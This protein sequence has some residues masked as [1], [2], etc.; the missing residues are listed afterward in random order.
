M[1]NENETILT[2]KN[3][4][5][6]LADRMFDVCF[7][8]G[9]ADP[10]M[11]FIKDSLIRFW[12]NP[13]I[14]IAGTVD[15]HGIFKRCSPG[16]AYLATHAYCEIT[17]SFATIQP[18]GE[19]LGTVCNKQPVFIE[20]N[21]PVVGWNGN[22]H[23]DHHNPGDKGYGG[24]PEHYW[25]S[26]SV[27]QVYNLLMF[28]GAHP[29]KLERAFLGEKR[30]LVAAS[31]H[32]PSHAY[33]GRCPGIDREAPHLF[34]A[35]TS[36]AFNRMSVDE[37]LEAVD[38]A[39]CRLRNLAVIQT[40]HGG[41]SIAE[42][43]IDMLNQASLI[44][45]MAVQYQT[46]GNARDPRRKMGILGGSPELVAHWMEHARDPDGLGLVNVYGDPARG[47]AGGYVAS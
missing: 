47:Y 43:E 33:Q 15:E 27:G 22:Y 10:E 35:E 19:N 4:A 7:I 25:E 9:A 18:A 37:W 12:D 31:D 1:S 8:L 14:F 39:C 29:L 38:I 26:S 17:Q 46:V 13:A 41:Y 6:M 42:E 11:E 28:W 45:G 30:F 16:N 44:L 36:A 34:R 21:I 3:N 23:V 2:H 32:C 24:A 40:P 5:A 20:C